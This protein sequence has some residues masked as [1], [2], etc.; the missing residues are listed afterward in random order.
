MIASLYQRGSRRRSPRSSPFMLAPPNS[1][2]TAVVPPPPPQPED[3]R[4]DRPRVELYE[5]ACSVPEIAGA[6]EQVVDRIGLIPRQAELL[7]RQL[8][9][10]RLRLHRVEI[11]R[12][13]QHVGAVGVHAA[14][15]E[16]PLVV[17]GQEAQPLIGLEGRVLPADRIELGD[18]VAQVARAVWN[19]R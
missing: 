17:G 16:D 13:E 7:A 3:E 5:A 19:L 18:Q 14:E 11:D 2:S 4:R 8:Q 10:G 1:R 6:T 12:D 9:P 15:A